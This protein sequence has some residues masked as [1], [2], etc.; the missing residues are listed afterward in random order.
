[1]KKVVAFI[2]CMALVITCVACFAA[3]NPKDEGG[4]GT[5]KVVMS[6]YNPETDG[7]M[8]VAMITDYGDITDQSFNQ[9][10]YEAC[11]AFSE[12]NSLGF[13]YFK[14]AGDS[15][16][17]RVASVEQAIQ[18]G[19]NVVVMPGYAFG[20]T[21]VEVAEQNQNVT[22][23][24]LDVAQG[25][26]GDDY[27]VPGN[28]ATFVYREEISGFMAG[29][30]AVKEGYKKLGFLGGMAVPAVVRFGYGFVQGVNTA[31]VEM[32]IANEVSVNYVYG[33]KFFGT[34]EITAA[35]DTWY[36][37]GTEV[38]FA[39]GGGIFTSACE[40]ATKEGINGKVIGVD[41]DQSYVINANYGKGVCVTSAMKGLAPT[42]NTVLKAI[43]DGNWKDYYGTISNMGMVSG[44]DP[45]LNYVQLPTATWSMTNFTVDDY[46]TLVGKIFDGTIS[47]SSETATMPAHSVNVTVQA[48]LT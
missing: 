30:A 47:V 10:T 39:C 20:E 45:S 36:K 31:A 7:A 3:C 46:K 48:N 28:V 15:T 38:V 42:V 16:E 23:I 11:K 9:T 17:A 18:E 1:M 2:L 24:A 8:K 37:N 22:F 12:A 19:Y 5:G 32:N 40:A 43:K 4:S 41:S 35:M 27:V 25:D 29:Y 14:P 6:G 13:K 34:P 33:G 44:T 21:V 26:L